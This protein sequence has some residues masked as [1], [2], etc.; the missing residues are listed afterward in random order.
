MGYN[1]LSLID[2]IYCDGLC[3][4]ERVPLEVIC[5]LIRIP[6]VN[7]TNIPSN[8]PDTNSNTNSR[9]IELDSDKYY[10]IRK[11]S[12]DKA[13]E[14]FSKGVEQGVDKLVANVGAAAAGGTA[15]ATVLKSNL[16]VVPKLAIAGASAVIVGASTKI[17][18]A[19]G[20]A[21]VSKSRANPA[22]DVLTKMDPDRIPSPT[23]FFVPS[24]LETP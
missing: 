6:P 2:T 22:T 17:G 18:I 13:V 24:V 10:H 9:K 11:D 23:E 15:A 20:E 5:Q 16:H 3:A 12:V 14:I 4:S 7:N 1:E 19:I 8:T 21:V